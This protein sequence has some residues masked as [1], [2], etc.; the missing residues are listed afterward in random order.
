MSIFNAPEQSNFNVLEVGMSKKGEIDSLTK[1]IRPN[2]GLI[3]NISYAHI[4][5]FKNLNQIAKAKGEMI[6]NI[7][8]NGTMIINMDDKYYKY[9][10]KKT[11]KNKLKKF[12]FSKRNHK[13]DITFLGQKNNK[14]AYLFKI[15][16]KGIIKSFIISKELSNYKENILASLSIITNYYDPE[17]LKKNLFKG[18]R[19]PKSRG[20]LIKYKKGSKKLT[21]LDESYNSNPL[22]LKFALQRFNS[23]NIKTK[24]KFLLIGDMLELGNY[25]RK[26]HIEIA[27]FINNSKVNKTYVYGDHTVHTFNKLKPQIKGRILTNT[28]DIYNLINKDLP[29]NSLLMV[30]GSNSTGLNKIIRKL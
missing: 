18:F 13:A 16:I 22:S 7:I 15:K 23:I 5:N 24:K 29:N 6:N 26:L 20:S 3:T 11:I 25:S 4:Q 14:N 27:K 30:K 9:F 21:V 28:M 12:T 1:L 10:L 19:I 2:L 8:H 17:K